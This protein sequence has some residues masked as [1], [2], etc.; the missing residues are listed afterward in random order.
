M[1][2]LLSKFIASRSIKRWVARY[3]FSV[4][5]TGIALCLLPFFALSFSNFPFW[6]DFWMAGLVRRIGFWSTQENFYMTWGG[7]YS[8]ALLQTIFNPLV[9]NWIDGFKYS[10]IIMLGGTM[11]SVLLGIRELSNG[12]LSN[13]A[14]LRWAALVLLLH[15][16]WMPTIYP[17]FYWFVGSV[18]YQ[19]AVILMVLVLMAGLRALRAKNLWA[20]YGWYLFALVAVAGVVGLQELAILLMGWTLLL[21]TVV[22]WRNG[23]RRAVHCWGGLLL[24]AVIG[25]GVSVFAPGNLVRLGSNTASHLNSVQVL[26]IAFEQL[27]TFLAHPN[28]VFMLLF[29]P[30]LFGQL[31][32]RT[33]HHRYAGFRLPFLA[34]VFFLLGGLAVCFVFFAFIS[35]YGMPNRTLNFVWSWLFLGWLLVLWAAVPE[36][37]VHR[38]QHALSLVQYPVSALV[39][40]VLIVGIERRAWTELIK[41]APLWK[42]QNNQRFEQFRAAARAGRHTVEV[43]AFSGFVP[44][45]I[46]IIGETLNPGDRSSANRHNN[47]VTAN[48]FGLDSITVRPPIL[49]GYFGEDL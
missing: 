1:A 13:S 39:I 20:R 22:S 21:L 19:V 47:R 37:H 38:M 11:F 16:A 25:G 3:R 4:L 29:T 9:Y 36:Q 12:Y 34:G 35:H 41:N 23:Y 49:P 48:W 42:V 6:D 44:R 30:V 7:R 2:F 32:L 26:A 46:A 43:S 15:L 33:R 5:G 17:A 45:H 31:L 28:Q 18:G 27:M 8:T 14:S 24:C 40:L 10:P